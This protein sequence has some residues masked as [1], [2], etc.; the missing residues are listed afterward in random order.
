MILS[1]KLVK[2]QSPM[3]FRMGEVSVIVI[4]SLKLVKSQF[5][6]WGGGGRGSGLVIVLDIW[7]E[8]T[9]NLKLLTTFICWM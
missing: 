6:I 3:F 9:M 4:L 8:F 1:S 7:R 5:P 2:S